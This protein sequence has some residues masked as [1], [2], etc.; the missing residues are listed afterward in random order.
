MHNLNWGMLG[1]MSRLSPRAMARQTLAI[2]S[3]HDP[4]DALGKLPAGS[5]DKI[6][7]FYRGHSSRR[8]AL[9]DGTHTVGALELQKIRQ[10]TL[11]IHSRE[12]KAVPFSHADWSLKHIHAA[13]LCEAGI[14][15]HFFWVDPD[16][17]RI[18]VRLIAFLQEM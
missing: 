6:T 16:F 3:G 11:A 2:F 17:E 14:T 4:L 1:L 7:R 12:N 8:G 15:S 9:C 18:R 5:I 13:E 10:P